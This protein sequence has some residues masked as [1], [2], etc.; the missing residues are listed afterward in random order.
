M[1]TEREVARITKA[2]DEY[3]QRDLATVRWGSGNPGNRAIRA[4]R[5][6]VMRELLT[7]HGL[8]PLAHRRVLE[9]GAGT[10]HMLAGLRELGAQPANLHG[11]DLLPRRVEQARRDYPELS[12]TEANAEQLPFEDASFDLVLLFIIL[13]SILDRDMQRNVAAECLRVLKPG[14]AIL[15]YDFRYDNPQNPDVRGVRLREVKRLFPGLEADVRLLTLVPQLARRLGRL[16]GLLYPALASIPP[17]RTYYMIL[18]TR[19]PAPAT[20]R[21][22]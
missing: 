4:E 6:R 9:V 18:L 12:F 5:R 7:A 19:P 10:G 21:P 16:T 17:L 11:V 15:W 8:L 13:S 20:H 22:D 1:T 3:D 2:Y 14:G